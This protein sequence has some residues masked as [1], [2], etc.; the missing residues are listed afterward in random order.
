MDTLPLSGAVGEHKPNHSHDVRKV[1]A[2]LNRHSHA[3]HVTV[4]EDGLFTASTLMAIHAFQR[5]VLGMALPDGVVGIFGLTNQ[6]LAASSISRLLSA[7][8]VPPGPAKS[9]LL[10]NA[11]YQAAAT[12]LKC[13]VAAIKAVASVE[14]G[15]YG[16]FD[17]EGRPTI[18]YERHIF[19][20]LTHHVYDKTHPDIS[21]PHAKGE[22]STP[23]YPKLKRAYRLDPNAALESTSWGAFQIMG[24]NYKLA[25]F[26][27][28]QAFVSSMRVSVQNQLAAFVNFIRSSSVLTQAIQK[29]NWIDFALH[30]NGPAYAKN[31]YDTKLSN[32]YLQA[33]KP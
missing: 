16:A 24:E 14:T 33:S 15:G 1:Q 10:S 7:F 32:A 2:H 27:S 21:G 20:V 31:H 11:D 13:E 29:K 5:R 4:K 19:S 28:V 18:L 23:S 8:P 17:S 25:G 12:T 22:Y 26:T 6:W 30:Y 9:S 3:T